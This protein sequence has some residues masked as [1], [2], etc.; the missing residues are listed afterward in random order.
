MKKLI[1][2]LLLFIPVMV[3]A[4]TD[5]IKKES[6]LSVGETMDNLEMLVAEKGMTVF[7]RIDHHKNA[8]EAGMTIGQSQLL[9]FGAPK[10]GTRIMMH[11]M[12]AGL[13]LPMRVLVYA[14]PLGQTWIAY[15]NP[16]GLKDDHAVEECV[17]LDKIEASLDSLTSAATKP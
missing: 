11:D 6:E 14:D 2:G 9:I 4:A 7:A 12:A 3:N 1:A 17:I 8:A 13:D 15:H 10:A 16:N 5:V